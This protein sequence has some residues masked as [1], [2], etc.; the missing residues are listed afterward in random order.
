MVRFFFCCCLFVWETWGFLAFS[1]GRRGKS[2]AFSD[3]AVH[4]RLSHQERP[5]Q[6]AQQIQTARSRRQSTHT[7]TFSTGFRAQ[8]ATWLCFKM[9]VVCMIAAAFWRLI[10]LMSSKINF[11]NYVIGDQMTT[12]NNKCWQPFHFWH[13]NVLQCIKNHNIVLHQK[14][15]YPWNEQ[16]ELFDYLLSM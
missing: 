5:P 12:K 2:A 4:C 15:M 11:F 16:V 7:N 6:K 10:P 1:Y 9:H 13:T 8:F 3:P 14:C